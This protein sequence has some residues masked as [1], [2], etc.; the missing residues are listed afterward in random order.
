M[1][2]NE[3][4][5]VLVE[6]LGSR[7]SDGLRGQLQIEP[8]PAQRLDIIDD[9]LRPPEPQLLDTSV[10]QNLDWV[11]RKLDSAEGDVCWDDGAVAELEDRFGKDLASDLLDLGTLYKQFEHH[12]SYPWLI[13]NAAVDEAS[14]LQNEKGERLRQLLSFLSGHQDELEGDSFPGI[15]KGLLLSR[16]RSRV[17]PLIRRAMGVTKSEELLDSSG[18]LSF[19]PDGGDRALV[20]QALLANI[21]AILTTNRRTFWAHRDKVRELGVEILRPSELL[22][23]YVPYWH[24]NEYEFAR[25]RADARPRRGTAVNEW[26]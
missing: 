23:L 25:R 21:P 14:Q 4:P 8:D 12:G 6:R 18:P 19:L 24:A 16:G 20:T 3:S 26:G 13:C 17:S 9:A 15:A 2:S 1:S 22:D 11:D 10:L 7:L 5:L